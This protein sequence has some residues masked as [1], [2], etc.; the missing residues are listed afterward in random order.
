MTKKDLFSFNFVD[1]VYSQ[2]KIIFQF[3]KP[4]SL[5]QFGPHSHHFHAYISALQNCSAQA[6]QV[7]DIFI[8]SSYIA[9]LRNSKYSAT[10]WTP[11]ALK[12]M[13]FVTTARKNG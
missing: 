13:K 5:Y 2:K 12:C 6:N 11:M 10:Y 8:H 9:V 7:K 1:V 4:M 3:L